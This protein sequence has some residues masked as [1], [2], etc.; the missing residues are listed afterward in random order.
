MAKNTIVCD[1]ECFENYFLVS[2]YSVEKNKYAH[3]ALYN[4]TIIEGS[5]SGLL[6]VVRN[7]TVVTFNG[8]SYDCI[9]ISAFLSNYSN[10]MLKKLSNSIIADRQPGWKIYREKGFTNFIADSIDIMDVCPL[11]ASLKI[12]GGRNNT[13]LLKDL[14]LDPDA[15]VADNQIDEIKYYCDNDVKMTYELY[16]FLK[17][18]IHLRE[19]LSAAYGTDLRSKGDAKI[20]ETVIKSELSKIT[21]LKK[22]VIKDEYNYEIPSYIS[23]KTNICKEL[24]Q[25]YCDGKYVIDSNGHAKFLF[26]DGKAKKNIIIGQTSYTCGI[27]GLH[28][29]EKSQAI[30]ANDEYIIRDSDVTSYYPNIIILNKYSPEQLKKVFLKVYQSIVD[31]RI[32]AKK[33]GDKNVANSLKIVIN[34]SFGKFGNKYSALYAPNLVIQTTITG[35]LSLLMLIESLE[36]AGIRV[37]SANTDGIVSYYK[38]SLESVYQNIIHEWE[39]TTGYSMELTEYKIL[40]SRDVN[41][42]IAVKTDNTVKGKG[43]YAD[44]TEHYNRLRVNPDA[45]ICVKA[46]KEYICNNI[47]LEKTIRSSTDINDFITLRKVTGGAAYENEEIG[48][49]IRWYHSINSLECIFYSDKAP[50]TTRGHKVPKTEGTV[51]LMRITGMPDDIDYDWYIKEAAEILKDIG[52]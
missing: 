23:M 15:I 9:M 31:K 51:P 19:V 12:Y 34:S 37:I 44:I 45:H 39:K 8:E 6:K 50:K 16:T 46:A 24:M 42:Y 13:N 14:P 3:V 48:K 35:Q 30:Y 5:L 18:E 1:V 52:I 47:P 41:N 29:N 2:L 38:R 36:L 27:G 20:A 28:S 11:E 17:D 49:A 4:D 26:P 10:K 7:N 43:A 32:A 22:P 40:A 33:S 25:I 21:T